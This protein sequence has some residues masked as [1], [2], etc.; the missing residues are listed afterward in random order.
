MNEALGSSL[1]AVLNDPQQM[2]QLQSLAQELL[3]GVGHES[4]GNRASGSEGLFDN[5]QEALAAHASVAETQTPQL[6]LQGV[7]GLL[8]KLPTGEGEHSRSHDLL[9]AM[10]PYLRQER[11]EKLQRAMRLSRALRL[12]SGFMAGGGGDLLG[13]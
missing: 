13:L 12:A 6:D 9:A 5:P 2:A 11:R 3:G 7:M 10:T 1:Q 4:G 8:K